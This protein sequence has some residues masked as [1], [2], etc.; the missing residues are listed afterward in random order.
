MAGKNSLVFTLDLEDHR[1]DPSFPKNYPSI[2]RELLTFLESRR[3]RATVFVLGRLAREEP[4]LIQEISERGH[5]VAYH[6]AQHLH[7]TKDTRENFLSESTDDIAFISDIIDK[8]LYG[9]RAPAFSLTPDS[10]WAVD[11]IKSLGFEYSSSVMPARNPI[12]GFPCAPQNPFYWQN[13]LLEIPAPVAKVGPLSLP[14]LG[15]IYLRYLPAII[16][17]RL[18]ANNEPDNELGN[19]LG[20][21]QDSAP[22]SVTDLAPWIYCHPHDFDAK[23][24]FFQIEGTS[25]IVSLVLWFNRKGTFK[26][27]AKILPNTVDGEIAQTFKEKI[28]EGAYQHAPTFNR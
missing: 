6:S 19:E 27:L 8:P 20:S 12:N 22:N 28:D 18:L 21:G 1:P 14:F 16:I 4:S 2:T 5:E 25:L 11:A 9:Y 17:K 7:L 10:L 26:K 24:P 13:G 15:G 23:E 3:I